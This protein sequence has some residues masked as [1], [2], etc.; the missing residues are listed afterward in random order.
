[1]KLSRAPILFLI[2]FDPAFLPQISWVHLP[3]IADLLFIIASYL[4]SSSFIFYKKWNLVIGSYNHMKLYVHRS[5]EIS[6]HSPSWYQWNTWGWT[7]RLSQRSTDFYLQ[8]WQFSKVQMS[9]YFNFRNW[10]WR[11]YF[12]ENVKKVNCKFPTA[13]NVAHSS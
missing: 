1:M 13:K 4:F 8:N 5:F 12:A 6:F 10:K 3:S 2:F 7:L 9:T 11:F